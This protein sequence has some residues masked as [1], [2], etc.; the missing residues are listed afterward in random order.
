MKEA[1]AAELMAG[2]VPEAATAEPPLCSP[3][4]LPL[5]YCLSLVVLTF[6]GSLWQDAELSC[7]YSMSPLHCWT[8]RNAVGCGR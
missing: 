7:T 8:G 6:L 5:Y 4:E 1:E 2:L 3:D